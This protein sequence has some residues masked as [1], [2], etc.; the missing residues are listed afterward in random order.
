MRT[1]LDNYI[2]ITLFLLLIILISH[3]YVPLNFFF[4]IP[5]YTLRGAGS[6]D[7]QP[8]RRSGWYIANGIAY[9]RPR[10]RRRILRDERKNNTS[11]N[12]N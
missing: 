2:Y 5:M 11:H 12:L 1:T 7:S 8:K 10:T 4:G 9:F 3:T 6:G